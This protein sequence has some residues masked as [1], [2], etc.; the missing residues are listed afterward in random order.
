MYSFRWWILW[1]GGSGRF[2][3]SS[4]SHRYTYEV[5]YVHITYVLYL[6]VPT[7]VRRGQSSWFS[8]LGGGIDGDPCERVPSDPDLP[9]EFHISKFPH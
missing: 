9:I 3:D 8:G 6:H 2:W 4:W 7:V 1:R 5:L